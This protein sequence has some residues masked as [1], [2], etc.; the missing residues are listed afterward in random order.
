MLSVNQLNAQIK[1]TEIWKAMNDEEHPFRIK[2][3]EI[4][5]DERVSRSQ[6]NGKIHSNA[7]STGTKNTFINDSIKAWNN[8]PNELKNNRCLSGAKATIKKFVATLPI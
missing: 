2:K 1:L 7:F 3:S 6:R 4:N 5:E 8:A